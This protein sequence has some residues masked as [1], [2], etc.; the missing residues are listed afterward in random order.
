MKTGIQDVDHVEFFVGDV[1]RAAS[2][3]CEAFGFRLAG[4]SG[5]QPDG[6]HGSVLLRQGRIQLLLT[7]ASDPAHPAAAYVQR[8]GDGVGVIAFG[9]SDTRAAFDEAMRNGAVAV[10]PPTEYVCPSARVVVAEV[11][12]FGDVTHRFV[13]RDG[14]AEQFVFGAFE[15]MDMTDAATTDDAEPL[16]LVD[17]VAVCLGPGTLDATVQMYRDVFGFDQIFE[18]IIEV[19]NQAMES[20]V[21]QSPSGRVTFTLIQ[22]DTSRSPGQIDDFLSR[23]G[24]PGVQHLAY[25]TDDIVSTVRS[26]SDRGVQF[27]ET[28]G[29][30]YD[31]L[32][33][34]LGRVDIDVEALRDTNVLV[35]R[36]HW[37]EVFQIFTETVH[38]RRTYFTEVID[39]HG[40][41]SFGS[42]NIRALYA[43]V[44][45]NA[46]GATAVS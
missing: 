9:T 44:Q 40:A 11:A 21:V 6:P 36:D 7:S 25:L 20:K 34:R 45:R 18:E 14:S 2:H 32:A 3:L 42:G 19:G 28:P 37:G 12:G 4:R 13:E 5:P 35:D 15:G 23:H 27:L 24:G 41:R 33:R 16:Q 38:E 17:H 30:Y 31:E 43:A 26:L 46:R 10:T 8:H 22:P 1:R 39:R 29:A